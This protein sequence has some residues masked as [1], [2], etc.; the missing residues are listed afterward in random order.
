MIGLLRG[1]PCDQRTIN[2]VTAETQHINIPANSP[3]NP[4][5]AR[6]RR[7]GTAKDAAGQHVAV[8]DFDDVYNPHTRPITESS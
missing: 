5:Y 3:S 1:G 4:R 8:F 6:Y 7:V 2:D